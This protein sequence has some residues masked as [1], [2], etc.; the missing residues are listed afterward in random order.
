MTYSIEYEKQLLSICSEVDILCKAL[1][2]EIASD[3]TVEK[4]NQYA[5]VLCKYQN[6]SETKILFE[7]AQ[8][9]YIPF[10]GWT[11]S[12]SPS[13]WKAY[14]KVKHNRLNNDNF[15]EGNLKN[16][17]NALCGLYLLNRLYFRQIKDSTLE[18]CP[19]PQS[20]IFSVDGWDVCVEIG[21]GFYY[22]LNADG[23]MS[24]V[25]G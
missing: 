8:K 15:K 3:K 16:V 11:P 23:R 14:N 6:M 17:F 20:Q 1:C 2:K 22:V 4:I 9:T 5:E 19:N 18:I 10:E 7:N 25:P 21:N 12:E 24:L 13:W